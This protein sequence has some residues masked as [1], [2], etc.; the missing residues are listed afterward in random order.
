MNNKI[1]IEASNIYFRGGF[2]LL[3]QIIEYCEINNIQTNVYIG[4][5]QVFDFFVTKEYE[6][7]ELIKT[8][9]LNTLLRYFKKRSNVLFFC[10]LPPFVRNNKSVLY[11]HNILFFQSPKFI[12]GESVVFNLKKFLYYFWI[13][14]FAKNVD[15]VAC[16]TDAVKKS[17]LENMKIESELYPF[18]KNVIPTGKEKKHEFCYV[19]SSANHKNNNRLLEAV[20]DLSGKYQF[21][22]QMTIEKIVDNKSLIEK[23]DGINKKHAREI[24]INRGMVPY[25]LVGEIYASSESLVFPSLFETIGLPLIEALQYGL[26][27]LSSDLEFTH[28]VVENPIVFNPESVESIKLVMEKQLKG[29]YKDVKQKNR[30]PSKLPQLIKLLLNEYS[31]SNISSN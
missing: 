27:I 2:V 12:K 4:Y 5:Q 1:I 22:L 11:A 8:N 18:Y 17:L 20:D 28:Q 9:G 21:K 19:G 7:I 26:K 16:Q 15:T 25:N 30:I 3:E 24:I 13:K 6:N 14:F 23:I 10:N 29:E 31:F